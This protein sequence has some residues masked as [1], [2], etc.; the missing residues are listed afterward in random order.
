MATRGS[1]RIVS[2]KRVPGMVPVSFRMAPAELAALDALCEARHH[3]R[4]HLIELAVRRCMDEGKWFPARD[5]KGS[6]DPAPDEALVQLS[7]AR[8][9][10]L[11]SL[12]RFVSARE[13]S[14]L[15]DADD[16]MWFAHTEIEANRAAEGLTRLVSTL[17][18]A[19]ET[20]RWVARTGNSEDINRAYDK[21]AVAGQIIAR[22]GLCS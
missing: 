14:Q 8:L 20:M 15:Q 21:L 11:S 6:V 18:S 13:A 9:M 10:L 19:F 22:R 2:G 5:G 16:L 17:R 12:G 7:S 3:S 1:K 4:T